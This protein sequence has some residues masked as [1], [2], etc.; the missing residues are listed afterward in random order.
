MRRWNGTQNFGQKLC[1]CF[2]TIKYSRLGG[3]LNFSAKNKTSATFLHVSE[4]Y[5]LVARGNHVVYVLFVE[6]KRKETRR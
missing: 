5:P 6:E 2:G 3:E 4:A 1:M